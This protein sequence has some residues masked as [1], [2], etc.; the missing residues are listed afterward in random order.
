MINNGNKLYKNNNY[1]EELKVIVTD[2]NNLLGGVMEKLSI[3]GFNGFLG[4]QFPKDLKRE[5]YDLIYAKEG[6]YI[7]KIDYYTNILL[8][9][10][11]GEENQPEEAAAE[12]QGKFKLNSNK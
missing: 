1:L 4:K 3:P 7:F 8:D 6:V 5:I 2:L 12:Q 9:S 10:A 11:E